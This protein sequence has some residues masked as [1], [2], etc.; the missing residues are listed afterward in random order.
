[1]RSASAGG[2][3]RPAATDETQDLM[4]KLLAGETLSTEEVMQL[5]RFD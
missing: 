2:G 1:M 5:Q 3:Q 4:A